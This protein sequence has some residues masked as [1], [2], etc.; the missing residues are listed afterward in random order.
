MQIDFRSLFEELLLKLIENR[1]A[2]DRDSIAL[3]IGSWQTVAIDSASFRRLL[4][5]VMDH[6]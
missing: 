1:I 4:R 2:V 5:E 3:S 6:N